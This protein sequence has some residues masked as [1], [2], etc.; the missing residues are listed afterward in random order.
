MRAGSKKAKVWIVVLIILGVAALGTMIAF[1]VD[2]PVRQELQAITI[3]NVDFT[4]LQDGTYIGEYNG[5]KGNSRDAAVEV[6]IW[7]GKIT[8]IRILKGALDKSGGPARLTEGMTIEDLF[9]SVIKSQSLQVDTISGATLTAKA[10]L[11]ALENALK[12]SQE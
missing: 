7:G 2:A 4:K 6:T 3:G 9:Q 1:F 12:Q 8:E 11:K 5:M 10:H